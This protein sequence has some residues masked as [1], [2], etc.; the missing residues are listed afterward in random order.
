MSFSGLSPV[1]SAGRGPRTPGRPVSPP[2]W[3]GEAEGSGT[4]F[5]F[6]L[7]TRMSHGFLLDVGHHALARLSP[8]LVE[9]ALLA[10]PPLV[11]PGL[12]PPRPI[13]DTMSGDLLEHRRDQPLP[14]SR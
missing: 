1:V 7:L 11:R 10:R 2:P 5:G 6:R 12:A 4:D 3:R 9:V 8:R 13:P 14:F